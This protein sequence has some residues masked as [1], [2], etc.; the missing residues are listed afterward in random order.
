[1]SSL[2]LQRA[3]CGGAG[4]LGSALAGFADRLAIEGYA[5]FTIGLKLATAR[6]LGDWLEGEGL[7]AKSL[8]EQRV[9]AFMLARDPRRRA[10]RDEAATG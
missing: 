8:D 9:E 3:N 6:D 1:M 4:P 2:F 5:H 7:A 10:H